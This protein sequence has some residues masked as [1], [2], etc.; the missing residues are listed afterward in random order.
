MKKNPNFVLREVAGEFVLVPVSGEFNGMIVLNEVG[1][2]IYRRA[3]ACPSEEAL[4]DELS[5]LFDAP[6]DEI[7][8]D[9]VEF[10]QQLREEKALID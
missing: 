10:L 8:A 6:R 4:I 3:E 5:D 9:T 7:A 1:A 2:E